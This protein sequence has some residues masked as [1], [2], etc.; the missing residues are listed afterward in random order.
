MD[1]LGEQLTTS[2]V[3]IPGAVYTPLACRGDAGILRLADAMVELEGSVGPP[4]TGRTMT[5]DAYRGFNL[6]GQR[7]L[8]QGRG[9]PE[10]RAA[11]RFGC[12]Y[13]EYL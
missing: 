9:S 6:P 7:P 4:K 8:A 12:P 2:I 3:A 10:S 11:S 13:A 1:E 5:I